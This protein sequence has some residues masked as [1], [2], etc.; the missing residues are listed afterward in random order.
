MIKLSRRHATLALAALVT[1][2][3]GL[4]L[5]LFY[6]RGDSVAPQ[7]GFWEP[8][9]AQLQV[10]ELI[11]SGKL[12]PAHILEISSPAA[13]SLVSLDVTLGDTVVKGQQLGRIDSLEL[14][15]KMRTAQAALLRSQLQDGA[16]LAGEEPADILNAR[17]R[18]LTTQAA[19]STSQ[20]RQQESSTLYSK[21]FVSRNDDEAAKT[22]MQNAEQQVIL[23]QEELKAATRKFAPDQ[24]KALKLDADNK[25]AEWV[26][27]I[28]RQKQLKLTAP[29]SGVVLYPPSQ[30]G[31]DGQPQRELAVGARLADGDAIL[32]IGDTSSFLIRGYCT[33]AEFNWLE[34]GTDVEVTLAALPEQTIATKVSKLLGQARA[35]KNSGNDDGVLYEFQVVF[36]A[37]DVGLSE[38]QQRKL[39][40]GGT[41]KLKITQQSALRQTS[42]PLAAVQWAPD[43]AAQVRWRASATDTPQMKSIRIV[44]AGQGDVLVRGVLAG[45]VWIPGSRGE[46]APA[47]SN[48]KRL[49]GLDE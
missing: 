41:A 8:I 4:M 34:A 44:R 11:S 37:A 16:V 3:V 28:E 25:Q 35:R 45:E 30:E 14:A 42:I 29:L 48:L 17:R 22:E 9:T 20:M 7:V 18:L 13:G 21:G 15:S 2:G 49:F 1:L 6:G 39:R 38:A 26:Q 36:V 47:T 43:G 32:A 33:E 23:A 46:A 10:N 12:Q 40:I 19:L 5:A 31:R 27:L 24:I